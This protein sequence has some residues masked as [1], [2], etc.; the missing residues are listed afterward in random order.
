MECRPICRFLLLL[1]LLLCILIKEMGIE[2]K[3]FVPYIFVC[4]LGRAMKLQFKFLSNI[5][6]Y[7]RTLGAPVCSGNPPL[8]DFSNFD[9]FIHS[10]QGTI[11]STKLNY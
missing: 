6:T 8:D 1:L 7:L 3:I 9:S 4:I 2:I 5:L 10:F 11:L